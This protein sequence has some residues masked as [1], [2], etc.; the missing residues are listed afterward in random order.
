MQLL[1]M[2]MHLSRIE[3]ESRRIKWQFDFICVH[4]KHGQKS[5]FPGRHGTIGD[6]FTH[7]VYLRG[8]HEPAL[9]FPF[10]FPHSLN[11][12]I[13]LCPIIRIEPEWLDSMSWVQLTQQKHTREALFVTTNRRMTLN[14][15]KSSHSNL[16]YSLWIMLSCQNYQTHRLRYRNR[17]QPAEHLT[18]HKY[19]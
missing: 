15:T 4:G 6:L 19:P 9:S 12:I 11:R 7:R 2:I 13:W 16:S 17:T 18:A 10:A 14:R 5:T 3:T 8:L 1:R